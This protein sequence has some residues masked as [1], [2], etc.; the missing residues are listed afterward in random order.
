[1]DLVFLIGQKSEEIELERVNKVLKICFGDEL[2][3]ADKRVV[4]VLSK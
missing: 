3:R 4:F 2:L 1:M